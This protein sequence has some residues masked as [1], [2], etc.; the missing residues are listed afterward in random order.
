MSLP[1]IDPGFQ[2][3]AVAPERLPTNTTANRHAIHRWFNFIAGFAPEFVAEHCPESA[4][5]ILLDP[6]AGCGTSLVVAQA[7][8]NRAIG[9]E[10]HPFFVRIARAKTAPP[11]TEVR[12]RVIEEVLLNGAA[13][14]LPQ[15]PISGPA[16][17]FLA[18]LFD[19]P[20]LTQLL[21]AR[22]ALEE[23]GLAED[24]LAFLLLSR[25]VEMCSRSQ[26]D[27]IYK[28]PTSR[29]KAA[30]PLDA[31]RDVID[32]I[33]SDVELLDNRCSVPEV[34]LYQRSSEDM[35]VV[36]T[37][38]IDVVVTSPPYLNNF[39]FAEMTRMQLY[40]WGL[41]GSWREITHKVRAHLIVNTTTALTGHR[42]IQSKYRD[43]IPAPILS[44]L[45]RI[46]KA[47]ARERRQRP[48]KK[49]YDLLVYPYFA[50]MTRVLRETLRCLKP[51]GTAH[52][53]V[54]DAAFYGIH[55]S[56]PQ[57]LASIM[58][59]LGYDSVTC[60]KLRDRG[61]RWILEKREG[62]PIGLGEYHICGKRG[63]GI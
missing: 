35:S 43:E 61:H 41:C 17:T 46:V 29:K 42:D 11:P 6:F 49:E 12:L 23:A 13:A 10:P 40:F 60:T 25:V 9:F 19:E 2:F 55:V 32:E 58:T 8:G 31:I 1:G 20:T 45:D 63:S 4:D 57:Y 21:A 38:S 26:T 15:S 54:A 44:D 3:E 59:A 36:E 47:L 28:A 7:S 18:K 37:G 33:R 51:G 52:V 5:G 24:D 53:V 27:G 50:Q 39:D 22:V 34:L 56:T 62:S 16:Q 30:P 48:G 14:A